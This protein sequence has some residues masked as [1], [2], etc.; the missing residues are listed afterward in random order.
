[1]YQEQLSEMLKSSVG[2]EKYLEWLGDPVTLLFIGSI[3]EAG[4]PHRP[5]IVNAEATYMALG[6]SLGMNAAA[7]MMES[8]R[9]SGAS[10]ETT[11]EASYGAT[12]V[13]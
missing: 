11:L 5:D 12:P 4:R 3:R 2:Q 10:T 1:M 9:Q 13:T 8:P 6:E 7:D